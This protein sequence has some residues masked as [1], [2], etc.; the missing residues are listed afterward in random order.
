M[1]VKNIIKLFVQQEFK[2]LSKS[3]RKNKTIT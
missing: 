3:N 1:R 2:K